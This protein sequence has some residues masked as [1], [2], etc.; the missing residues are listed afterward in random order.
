MRLQSRRFAVV[1]VG[2]IV[3]LCLWTSSAV[4]QAAPEPDGAALYRQNCRSCH[5]VKGVPPA[6]MVSV[7]PALK[8]LADSALSA[9]L[10]TDSIIGVL[11]HGRGKDMKPFADRLSQAEMA[12]VA[13]FV[14]TFASP[15]ASSGP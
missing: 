7:Y 4:A 9:R 15:A 14:K 10:T 5:G 11:K 2:A 8:S 6:R 1:V 12:A 3:G 13:K